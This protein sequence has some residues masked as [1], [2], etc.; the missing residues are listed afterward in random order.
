MRGTKEDDAVRTVR[1][2]GRF[3]IRKLRNI[4]VIGGVVH[5]NRSASRNWGVL[6]HS[7]GDEFWSGRPPDL[8]TS[9]TH[10]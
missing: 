3:R 5:R 9:F 2:C 4:C 1:D 6:T 10:L 7:C 8:A